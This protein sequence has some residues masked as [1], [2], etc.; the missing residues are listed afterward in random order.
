MVMDGSL[1]P[2]KR[3]WHENPHYEGDINGFILFKFTLN[4]ELYAY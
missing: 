1:T 3:K 2:V 4:K